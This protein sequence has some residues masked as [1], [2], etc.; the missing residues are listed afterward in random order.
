LI[1]WDLSCPDW[2]S[3]IRAGR[4]PIPELPLV[5]SEA[6]VAVEFFNN[7]RLPDVPATPALREASG[8]WFRDIVAALFGSWDPAAKVRHI[9]EI[10]ALVSK[11]NSKTTNGAALMLVALLMSRRPRAEYLLVGP[12]HAIS[13]LAFSQAVGMVELDPALRKRFRPR[14]HVKEIVDLLTKAKLKIKTFDLD[15]LTGPRP[16]GV[17]VDEL[18][19]LGKHHA[20]GKVLRQIRGGMEKSP[21]GFMVMI[22]TQSDEPPAGAFREELTA[23]REIRDGRRAG[24]MLPVLYE[25][26]GEIARDPARWQDPANWPMV[27]PNL[28]RS[29]NLDS[30]RWDWDAERQK[31]EHAIRIWAS[32]HLNIEI[33]IGLKTD[34]WAGADHWDK[35]VDPGLTFEVLLERS[36]VVVVGIDGGGL[37]DLF[38]LAAL[39]RDRETKDWLL[40]S[41]GWCHGGVLE[42][43]KS[44]AA[45]LRDFAAAGELTIVTDALDDI[46]AIVA[47]VEQ[48]KDLG[49][50][51]GVAVDPA[52]LGEFVDAM[53]AI[54][55][56]Q[57]NKLL[58]GI[59]QG[60][61]MMNAIKTAERRLANGTLKHAAQ[62]LMTWCVGNLKIEPTATAIRATKQNAGDA[63]IDP[64]M[65]MFDAID[66]MS[67]NP[68]AVDYSAYETRD[69]LVI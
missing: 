41:H 12:T 11:G 8:D 37:D 9:R 17:L 27:M 50:L 20:T 23:A 36:E 38:G 26:P 31:G 34:R 64:A 22:T 29:L 7:N 16:V 60:Y 51:G 57:D 61:R 69:L 25:F 53:A 33:G 30:L 15:V 58:I 6:D 65:A 1:E 66:L 35:G 4:T 39:G 24:R 3:R 45:K 55:V 40:W 59:G 10:F 14:D 46:S 52:G 49:L 28:G 56:T 47:L 32:Q 54:D 67:T 68:E 42:R 44:I 18:H 2:A 21:E 43:R 13:D 19:L 48:I 62:S 5:R 63:K